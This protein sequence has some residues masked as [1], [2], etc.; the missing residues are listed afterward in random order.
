MMRLAGSSSLLVALYLVASAATAYAECAWVLWV[1][2][3]RMNRETGKPVSDFTVPD[4]S[5]TTKNECDLVQ[6]RNRAE[7]RTRRAEDPSKELY[8]ACFPDTVDPRGPRA[9]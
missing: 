8:F 6:R 7:E 4:E 9:K 1:T 3:Y 5:F 2:T